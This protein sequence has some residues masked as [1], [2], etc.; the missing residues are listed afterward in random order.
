[1]QAAL[2]TISGH[3]AKSLVL[4]TLLPVA[5]VV[6]IWRFVV[7]PLLL[8]DWDF[9]RRLIALD[10]QWNLGATLL[11]AIVVTGVLY[12]LNIPLIRLLE[13]Y[14]WQRTAVGRVRSA[15]HLAAAAA[16]RA[17]YEGMRTL[18][19][20]PG[21]D[22]AL[23]ETIEE[24][25]RRLGVV[26]NT[27]FPRDLG[28]VLPTRLGNALASFEDYPHHQYG[29]LA[30]HLWPRLVAVIPKEYAAVL[31]DAKASVD[32]MVNTAALSAAL[33]ASMVLAVVIDPRPF[34]AIE[35]ALSWGLGVAACAL[36][37]WLAYLGGIDRAA[38]W[39]AV[40]KSAFD[41]YRAALLAQLGYQ[42]TPGTR[43]EERAL[44]RQISTQIAHG[45]RPGRPAPDY[46]VRPG[47]SASRPYASG[48]PSAAELFV[49]RGIRA[50][51]VFGA[52]TV[53]LEVTNPAAH[54]VKAVAVT[55]TV[56]DGFDYVHG[57][58]TARGRRLDT[59]GVN[60]RRFEIGT[61]DARETAC[62]T[63]QIV[64]YGT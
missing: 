27:R 39:G 61:L 13:G 23:R 30:V 11:I 5:V 14:P 20:A 3:F 54:P 17:R 35:P 60:P 8:P 4:G 19:W 7:V 38:A 25:R 18:S 57:S 34:A 56:P 48:E 2:S 15:H 49:E 29:M 6:A 37:A 40:V 33:G 10:Q 46:G 42:R 44:W 24:E 41:L 63:Y 1:M 32:F 36:I 53:V 26:V 43:A 31:D 58:A 59:E 50:P 55:D 45:D 64:R 62:V 28:L 52:V 22:A 12:N 47:T 21:A 16:A 9:G 51:N